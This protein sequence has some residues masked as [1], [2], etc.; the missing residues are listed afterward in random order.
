M[1]NSLHIL[2]ID[3]YD[4]FT[5]N[6][7]HYLEPYCAQLDVIRTRELKQSSISTYDAIV[8]SPGPGLPRDYHILLNVIQTVGKTKPILGICLGHQAIAEAFGGK[9]KN[10]PEVFHG[11]SRMTKI[12]ENDILFDSLPRTILTGRYHSWVADKNNF[13]DELSIT[14]LDHEGSIMALKHK[15]F[16]IKGVQ[17]HPE[18]I[19]TPEGKK[20]I[21]NWVMFVTDFV[22]SLT[23]P[24]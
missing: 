17:F 12:I 5:F 16:P 1:T 20:I 6:L 22:K 8:I 15:S 13:P 4:S 23:K 10:L 19:L 24:R 7:Y 18:S 2:I 21:E 14:A 3:N 9:L 11:V